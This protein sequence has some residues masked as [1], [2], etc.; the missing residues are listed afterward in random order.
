MPEVV[1]NAFLDHG[2]V[3]T[4]IDADLPEATR[5]YDMVDELGIKWQAVGG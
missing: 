1:L 5:I 4:T 3:A 2:V